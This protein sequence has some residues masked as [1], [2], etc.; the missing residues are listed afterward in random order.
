MTTQRTALAAVVLLASSWVAFASPPPFWTPR[1]TSAEAISTDP[2][3]FFALTPCRVLDT[4]VQPPVLSAG[5]PRLVS[6]T[7]VCGVPSTALAVSLNLTVTQ[8]QG[9]GHLV[10]FPTGE[11]QP[12][13]SSLN[14]VAGQTRANA[15]VVPTG[16]AGQITVIAGA[17]GTHVIVDVNGYYAPSPIVSSLNTLEGDV[18]I[19]NGANVTVTP[20]GNTIT[21]GASVATGPPGST[22][23]TG[24][25]GSTGPQG[26]QGPI[27][28]TGSQGPTGN[29]GPVGPQGTVGN[30]GPTGNQGPQGTTGN[31]GPQ[32]T[33]GPDGPQGATGPSGATG[34]QGPTGP[35]GLNWQADWSAGTTYAIDDA[36]FRNGSSYKSLVGS[37]QGNDPESSP[38]SWD[39][40]APEGSPG[41]IGA[42]GPQ[43]TAGPQG[44]QGPDGSTGPQGPDGLAGPQGTP[45]NQGPDGPIGNT[46]PQG[47]TGNQGPQ[48]PQGLVGFQGPQGPDGAQG[49]AGPQGSTG[50][51]GAVGPELVASPAP[52]GTLITSALPGVFPQYL[53]MAIGVDGLP[54]ISHVENNADLFVTHCSNLTCSTSTTT[55]VDTGPGNAGHH[56]SIAIGADGLPVIAYQNNTTENL[57]VAHCS[58]VACTA[59]I[60]TEIDA[61]ANRVGY[62]S[63]ITIGSDGLPIIGY[64]DVT[65]GNVWV[66]HCSDAIC[67]SATKS[68]IDIS[69]NEVGHYATI[70]TGAD[71]LAILAYQDATTAKLW[72]AHCDNVTCTSATKTLVDNEP[73]NLGQD[74]AITIGVDGLPI[75]AY[76]RSGNL[77]AAHCSDVACLASIRTELADAPD[78]NGLWNSIAI[79]VDGLPIIAHHISGSTGDIAFVHCS[80]RLCT[81]GTQ[82]LIDGAGAFVGRFS[83]LAIGSDGFPVMAYEKNSSGTELRVAHCSNPFC[84]PYFRR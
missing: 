6:G 23:P 59:S 16:T 5:V 57:W 20:A 55:G 48:G 40:L 24:N 64:M 82:I 14:Y 81:S 2:L 26:A 33:I 62:Y 19:S 69:A 73:V 63:S 78:N 30:Q 44:N 38:G 70:A 79:G 1:P 29:Q 51:Q 35:K 9:A 11:P 37:N 8:T 74:P 53:S 80:N 32:G 31:Q 58:N 15:A 41:A 54:V 66:A 50:P 4:R 83:T 43:G 34:P 21:V 71:G 39:L 45:G 84:V 7:G 28:T 12:T 52:S 13:V 47:A 10:V 67:T 3:P 72:V 42:T 46:G 75:I 27:G 25:Q 77:W 68:E 76:H 60:K 18:T 17:S 22:G 36:V 65:S 61:S 56:S 49:P